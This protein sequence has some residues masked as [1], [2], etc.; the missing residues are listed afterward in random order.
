M[1]LTTGQKAGVALLLLVVIGVVVAWQMGL[2]GDDDEVKMDDMGPMDDL[3]PEDDGDG[4]GGDGLEPSPMGRAPFPDD[5]RGLVGRYTLESVTPTQWKDIS[6][7]NNHSVKVDGMLSIKDDYVWGTTSDRVTFPKDMPRAAGG[8]YTLFYVARYNGSA[9]RGRMFQ[10][11]TMDRNWLSGFHGEK[12]GVAHH[13]KWITPHSDVHAYDWVIATDQHKLFR[14]NGVDRTTNPD[15]ANVKL[16]QLGLNTG[17]RS[18]REFSDW[19]VKEILFYNRELSKADIEKVEQYLTD[20]HKPMFRGRTIG[21]KYKKGDYIDKIPGANFALGE[22]H[23]TDEDCRKYAE[24]NSWPMWGYRRSEAS[25]TKANTC[26]FHAD[27][28]EKYSDVA[29]DWT[30]DPKVYMGCTDPT[31]DPNV[32]CL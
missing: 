20:T 14:S 8:A 29:S 32:S 28:Y 11:A 15:V 6:G 16:L 21:G 23:G 1:A 22:F 12:A 17:W 3:G 4:T 25:G 26:F 9:N 2:F 18:A 7:E 27:G 30:R 31:K 5:I 13:G 24:E 10:D 19:A